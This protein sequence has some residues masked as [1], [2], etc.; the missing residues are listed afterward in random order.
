MTVGEMLRRMSS[1]ELAEW[2]AFYKMEPFGALA[3]DFRAGL[4]PALKTNAHR[5]EGGAITA[6]TD[7]F[8]WNEEPKEPAATDAAAVSASVVQFFET[9][10]Q[11]EQNGR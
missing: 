5:R 8:P 2:R 7:F 6:P 10:T 9:I 4:Y 1:A 11:G 3:D